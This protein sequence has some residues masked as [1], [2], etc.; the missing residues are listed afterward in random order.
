M[1]DLIKTGDIKPGY[2]SDHSIIT[3]DIILSNFS[4]GKR[5]WKFNNSLLQNRDY[6]NLVN[7][8][9]QEERHTLI[10]TN[11]TILISH[12]ISQD[13]PRKLLYCLYNFC[14]MVFL[15]I[16]NRSCLLVVVPIVL[17]IVTQIVNTLQFPLSIHQF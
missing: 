15:L 14:I 5:T 16:L 10:T 17:G 1:A 7:K 12:H 3:M 9:I 2:R 13:I 11:W 4:H 6:L 8:I